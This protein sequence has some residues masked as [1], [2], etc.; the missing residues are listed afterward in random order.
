MQAIKDKVMEFLLDITKINALK[1]SIE[2]AKQTFMDNL[3][4]WSLGACVIVGMV[5][6]LLKIMGFKSGKFVWLS[7]ATLLYILISM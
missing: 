1:Q 4:G 6:L 5:A 2:T 3:L 7:L